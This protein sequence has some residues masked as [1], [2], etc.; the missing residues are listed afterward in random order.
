MPMVYSFDR[1]VQEIIKERLANPALVARHKLA[2]DPVSVGNELES[3]TR[4]RLGIPAEPSFPKTI[5]LR[6]LPQAAAEAVAA[7]AKTAEGVG[8]LIDWLKGDPNGNIEVVAPELAHRRANV[9]ELCPQNSTSPFTDWFTVPVAEKLRRMVE[10]RKEI[11]LTTPAD[12]KLGTC[13]V[14]RCPLALKV[15]VPMANIIAKTK[16]ETMAQFPPNCWI[17]TQDQ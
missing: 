11:K 6:S 8:L 2:T 5:P 12:A 9:C 13:A 17:K 3:Y 7:V 10:A 1:Q 15:H 4:A 14:C 16:P